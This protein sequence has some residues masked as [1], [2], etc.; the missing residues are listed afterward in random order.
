MLAEARL[1]MHDVLPGLEFRDI[2][3]VTHMSYSLNSLKGFYRGLYRGG[4]MGL[5]K[6]DTRSLDYS[7]Y[8]LNPEP[9]HLKPSFRPSN[10]QLKSPKD[11][12][13]KPTMHGWFPFR[14]E[15]AAV[16]FRV[17]GFRV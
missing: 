4:I 7:P 17:S 14:T 12:G 8:V 3:Q 9:N 10:M 2:G 11:E 15:Q 16:G 1:K 5:I 13:P 6:G